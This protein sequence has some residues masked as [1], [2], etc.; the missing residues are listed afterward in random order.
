MFADKNVISN[1]W[2]VVCVT[3]SKER[4]CTQGFLAH[5]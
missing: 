1:T 3:Q 2:Y 5:V 4:Q